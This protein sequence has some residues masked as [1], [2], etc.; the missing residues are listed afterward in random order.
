M[1]YDKFL[2]RRKYSRKI[3]ILE[4]LNLK[5]ES[6]VNFKISFKVQIIR[7]TTR[8]FEIDDAAFLHY[9]VSHKVTNDFPTEKL[10]KIGRFLNFF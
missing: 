3:N 4:I 9:T 1:P 8:R 2:L 10:S 5:T 7:K 6:T